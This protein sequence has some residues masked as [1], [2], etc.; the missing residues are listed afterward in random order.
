M[1]LTDVKCMNAP[2][3]ETPSKPPIKHTDE[4]N[5]YWSTPIF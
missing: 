3:M 2:P 4:N 1:E 5:P